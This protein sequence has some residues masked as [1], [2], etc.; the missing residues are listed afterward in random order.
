[1]NVTLRPWT[2]HDRE[3]LRTLVGD[4]SLASQFDK[5]Q[6]AHGLEHKLHDPRLAQRGIRLAFV[7]GTPAGFGLVWVLPGVESRWYM[8]R[9]GVLERF[10]RHGIGRRLAGALLEFAESDRAGK[11][12]DLAASAWM[13]NEAAEALAARLGFAHE[14]WFWLME[15]PRGEA[16]V[17]AWPA[18]VE[19]REYDGSEAMLRQWTEVYNDSF[20][21]HYRFVKADTDVGRGIAADPTFRPDGLLLAY[22]DG[23]CAGFCRNELHEG[24]GEIAVLGVAGAAR[25]IGLGRAL[26]RWGVRW[27]EANSPAKV[28]LMVDGENENALR[29]YR[30]EGFAV[31]RT[32]HIWACAATTD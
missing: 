32:R 23:V 8:M 20:A 22:R 28:T 1:M 24:R 14:R 18:G 11:P 13:P 12:T 17:V 29:L 7:D 27:L 2:P 6:G 9:V 26:L 19:T 15:R 16:P 10:R 4:P 5:F 25:G 3:V 30:S 21:R 31:E